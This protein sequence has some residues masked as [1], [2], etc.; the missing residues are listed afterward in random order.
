MGDCKGLSTYSPG[1]H[2]LLRRCRRCDKRSALYRENCKKREANGTRGLR[3]DRRFELSDD[4]G[5]ESGRERTVWFDTRGREVFG[6]REY[7]R[8][9]NEPE[10]GRG[11]TEKLDLGPADSARRSNNTHTRILTYPNSQ[12][13]SPKL[14]Y[15][16]SAT[17]PETSLFPNLGGG[18]ILFA[19]SASRCPNRK[20]FMVQEQAGLSTRSSETLRSGRSFGTTHKPGCTADSS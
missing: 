5:L 12:R 14:A 16:E 7:P 2:W 13:E 11:F 4:D 15:V 1:P 8:A 19:R 6:G 10:I 20:S 17:E 3:L 18:L 9:F